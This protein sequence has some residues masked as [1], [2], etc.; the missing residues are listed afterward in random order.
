MSN[1]SDLSALEPKIAEL[2]S[3]SMSQDR[4]PGLSIGI[5]R[6]DSL[7]E[8]YSFGTQTLGEDKPATPQT[9]SR[10]ASITKTFTGTA[11]LQ[12]RDLGQL[13][14]D[15][16]LL[17]HMPDFTIANALRGTLEGVT[18]RRL[19]THYSGLR[20]E[21]PLTDWNAPSF[22]TS[23]ELLDNLAEIDVVIPQDSQWKYSNLAVG[24][25]GQVVEQLSG[26]PYEQYIYEEITGPLGLTNTRFDLDDSQAVLKATGYSH[27]LPGTDDLRI[28]PYASLRGISAAGQLHS[29]VED[30]AKWMSFQ[31]SSGRSTHSSKVLSSDSLAEMHRPVYMSNDWSNGQALSWRMNR[32]DDLVMHN[33]GGGIQGYASN[34]VFS[35]K[36]QTG[37]IVL[38]NIWPAPT[39]YVLAEDI[40]ELVIHE[41]GPVAEP[42]TSDLV[43]V[44]EQDA[45][46]YLGR[47][48]AEPGAYVD[49]VFS[50]GRFGLGSP[51]E[52]DYTLHGPAGLASDPAVA[53]SNSFRTVGGRGAGELA[54]FFMNDQGKAESF[55]LGG[56]LYKRVD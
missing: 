33:H 19:M 36:A 45:S 13:E 47:F 4:I 24:L 49:V 48:W 7:A 2:A 6:G 14:L 51:R 26:V 43:A 5:V 53:D 8:H 52:G 25:L 37:V 39:P 55:R 18:L 20:T 29:N 50:D 30:L 21:H 12:L 17:V 34:F 10:I 23:E 28:A 31:F 56:F 35:V 15:D 41:L 40:A 22:P 1:S 3:E 54:E 16:P 11:I 42:D 32:R 44:S 9:I 38:A 46:P 27:P